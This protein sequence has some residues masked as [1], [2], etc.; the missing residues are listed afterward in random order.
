MLNW[1][2]RQYNDIKGNFKWA[3]IAALW[4]AVVHYGRQMLQVIPNIPG[5][6]VTSILLCLSLAVFLWLAKSAK[7]SAPVPSPQSSQQR[8][9]SFPSLSALYGHAPLL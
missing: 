1:F 6:L 3:C 8:S 9:T 4:W 7:V 2:V 5:W